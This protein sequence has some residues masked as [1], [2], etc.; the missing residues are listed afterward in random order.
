MQEILKFVK[1][2]ILYNMSGEYIVH[3]VECL[4]FKDN[5]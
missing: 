1:E 5:S 3:H 2:I 4:L